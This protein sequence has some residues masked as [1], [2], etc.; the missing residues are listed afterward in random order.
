MF[1]IL[2]SGLQNDHL[3]LMKEIEDILYEVHAEARAKGK[4]RDG[5]VAMEISPDLPPE[6]SRKPFALVDHVDNGS[7]SS[8]AGLQVNDELVEFGSLNAD[9]FSLPKVAEV[10]KHSVNVSVQSSKLFFIVFTK[11]MVLNLQFKNSLLT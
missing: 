6:R 11:L 3:D 5:P 10:V 2:L 7:P 9:N 1:Y 8:Q 4:D